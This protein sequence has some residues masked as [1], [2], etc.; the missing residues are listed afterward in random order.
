MFVL[1]KKEYNKVKSFFTELQFHMMDSI[2]QGIE[3]EIYV[4]NIKNPLFACGVLKAY[5]FIS[6]KYNKN[7]AKDFIS[8]LP[9]Q[10]RIINPSEDWKEFIKEFYEGKYEE[11]ERYCTVKNESNFDYKK[12]NSYIH[13]LDKKYKIAKIDEV[14]YKQVKESSEQCTTIGMTENYSKNGIGI[15]CIEGNRIIG[16]AT[17]NI[18]YEDGIEINI[19]VNEEKR[20]EGI[21]TAI[22]SKLIIECIDNNLYPNWDAA[23]SNSVGLAKKLGYKIGASYYVYLIK[24]KE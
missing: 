20:N 21:A 4:D 11:Y 7:N 22:A 10:V 2:F 13:R 9:N 8:W 3:G 18:I 5:C 12:L 16:L 15:C 17:S 19:K 1:D 23:N 14:L 24:K 6:G